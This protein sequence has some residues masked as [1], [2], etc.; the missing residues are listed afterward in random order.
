MDKMSLS[1]YI[2]GFEDEIDRL[3]KEV[4]GLRDLNERL[5]NNFV[6]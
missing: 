4:S 1:E 6:E 3:R 2:K 5:I